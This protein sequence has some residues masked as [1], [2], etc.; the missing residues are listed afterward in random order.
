MFIKLLNEIHGIYKWNFDI[1]YWGNILR[2]EEDNFN[3]KNI[4]KTLK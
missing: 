3:S 2:I 4:I 1:E